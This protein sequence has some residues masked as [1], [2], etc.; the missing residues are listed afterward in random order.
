MGLGG[1]HVKTIKVKRKYTV[2]EIF[3]ILKNEGN[4]PAE[5]YISGSGIMRGLFVP[6]IGK[7]DVNIST[8]GKKI[9]CSEYV[10]RDAQLHTFAMD[11]LTSGWSAILD[12]ASLDNKA[13]TDTVAAEVERLFKDRD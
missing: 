12:Q 11:S 4:L 1:T 13:V 8:M 3:E 10:R 5:P 7:Y 2:D 9:L 6:G